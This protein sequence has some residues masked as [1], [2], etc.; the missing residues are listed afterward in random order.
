[1]RFAQAPRA[2]IVWDVRSGRVLWARRPRTLVPIASLTKMMTALLADK[3]LRPN[4][5]VPITRE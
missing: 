2:G 3:L 4:A 5:T 1:M